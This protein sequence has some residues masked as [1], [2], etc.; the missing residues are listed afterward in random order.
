MTTSVTSSAISKATAANPNCARTFASLCFY[1]DHLISD[2]LTRIL[3]VAPSESAAKGDQAAAPNGR[4][5][6]AATGRW[7]LS[8]E[9]AVASFDVNDHVLW[10]LK[11]IMVLPPPYP[12]FSH[13]GPSR[14]GSAGKPWSIAGVT[15]AWV[16]CYW[17]SATGQGGPSLPPDLMFWLGMYQ[18]EL[19]FDV[20]FAGVP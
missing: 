3:G 14:N 13:A 12:P 1:G 18:L 2:E 15:R 4:V 10:L 7:I 20:Y 16:N 5:R 19:N 6:T 8:S 11:Q 9:N 17:E